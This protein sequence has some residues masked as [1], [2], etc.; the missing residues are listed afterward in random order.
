M[1]NLTATMPNRTAL[2]AL[3]DA[4][5]AELDPSR[6][7]ILTT[8]F[9]AK[10][11]DA[12]FNAGYSALSDAVDGT[13]R[14]HTVSAPAGG[15]KTTFAYALIAA[16]TRNADSS[17]DV[18]YGAVFVVDQ[19]EKADSVYRDLSALLPGKVAIWT[20]DHD[21]QCK[22][23]EK[24]R[25]P[26]AQ[27][28]REELRHYPVI[29]VTHSF[30]LG[31]RGQNAAN[32]V[33]D[34]FLRPRALTVVDERPDEAPALDVML[35]EAQRVREALIDAYPETKEH[36]HALLSF[37]E[38]Y[39]Y[40]PANKLY[41]TGIELDTDKVAVELGWF[42]TSHAD[43]LAK[44]ASN[45]PGVTKLFA[46]ANALVVGR[47][48]VATSG[49]LANFFGYDEQRVIDRSAG[50]VL[51]DATADIDGISHIVPWRVQTETPKARYDNLEIVHV[52]QHTKKRL[53][54]YLKIA[55]NQREYVKWVVETITENMAPGEK[56]LVICKKS[57]FD[58]ERIPQWP[59]GDV[60]FKDPKTYTENYGW[61]VDGRK[62]CATHWGTGV[63][64]NAW[65]EA[66][67]V[68]LF[69]EFFI[70]R[71]IAV[72]TT[73]GLRGHKVNEGDL[74]HM[75]NL[76]SKAHGVDLIADGHAL[77]WTKQLAL[78]G[79]ARFYDANGVCSKQRLVV[80][81]DL[82]R[83]MANASKL[84]PGATIR[85]VGNHGDDT[86]WKSR[87]LVALNNA[88]APV[89]TTREL[90]RVMKRQWREVSR[91]VVTP[92]FLSVITDLGWRYV[93]KKGRGGCRFERIS[94]ANGGRSV[95]ISDVGE[96]RGTQEALQ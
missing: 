39:S 96:L 22:Q 65:R 5:V 43:H 62:L 55:S 70:P 19:I 12:V 59:E 76:N 44:S 4:A 64:S 57:L 89:V 48:C 85:T 29:V 23:P 81:S 82:Q 45:I 26:A 14:M 88:K 9:Y 77:R 75:K 37:M 74:G 33:R 27:F 52:P 86:T 53:S 18:P 10:T 31:V 80:G 16:I 32:V 72:A 25:T 7:N 8:E 3:Y 34:G 90:T 63:G 95:A 38:N 68:F 15:G 47:A 78:R 87:V 1:P 58:A 13:R 2:R 91:N 49:A 24:V 73:Q 93:S 36:L 28:T 35:S 66:D 11:G 17:P 30:Y 94:Q 60:R 83:F 61:D 54:E 84:F 6:N 40:A 56:G 79:R 69:D 20:K 92:E 42:R 67:V 51:L 41:R 50:T 21:R 46:F 71:R